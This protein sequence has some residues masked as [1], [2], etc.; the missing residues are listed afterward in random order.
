MLAD[1]LTIH[2]NSSHVQAFLRAEKI[3]FEVVKQTSFLDIT[4]CSIEGDEE[5]SLLIDFIS[6][7]KHFKTEA[8][9]KLRAEFM[10]YIFSTECSHRSKNSILLDISAE[11]IIIRK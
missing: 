6:H 11:A 2:V 10:D 9:P 5:G 3:D 4:C 7:V 1:N 8:P